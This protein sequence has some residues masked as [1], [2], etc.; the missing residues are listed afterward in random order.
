MTIRP[1]LTPWLA[2]LFV[3]PASRSQGI[4]AALVQAV[5][6]WTRNQEFECL[7]LYTSGTLPGYYE[8]LGFK[9][10]EQVN[11]LG[12]ERTIMEYNLIQ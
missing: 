5:I 8:R 3:L 9:A 10:R 6:E 7:Y 4:G 2:Q 1:E 11:Y 12:K